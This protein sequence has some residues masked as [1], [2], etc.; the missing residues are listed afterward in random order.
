LLLLI[1]S[2]DIYFILLRGS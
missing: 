1:N 2:P